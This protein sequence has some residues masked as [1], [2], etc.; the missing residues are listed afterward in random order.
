MPVSGP[1]SSLDG[2]VDFSDPIEGVTNPQ[3]KAVEVVVC[4]QFHGIVIM[5]CP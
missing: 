5:V 4:F 2:M 3:L 1:S